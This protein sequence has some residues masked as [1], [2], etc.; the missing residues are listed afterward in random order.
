MRENIMTAATLTVL[1]LYIFERAS[2]QGD[3]PVEVQNPSTELRDAV[4]RYESDRNLLGRSYPI[5]MSSS[6][7]ER[8]R[9][10]LN[11]W[12]ER[13][14]R[15]NFD[16]L[17][18]DGRI[19]FLLFDNHLDYELRQ[20]DIRAKGLEESRHF[21][22]FADEVLL[23]E[24]ERRNLRFIDGESAAKRLW[25][26]GSQM[27]STRKALGDGNGGTKKTVAHRA[28][29]YVDEVR[30]ILRHWFEFYNGYDPL[31]T[32]WVGQP[33]HELDSLM[34]EYASF[35]RDKFVGIKADDKTTIIGDPIGREALM[36]ELAHEMIPYTPDELIAI[37]RK[38]LSWCQAEMRLASN[39]LG[40]GDDWHAALEHVKRQHVEPGK[41]TE[42][43]RDL[44]HEAVGFLKEHDLLTIPPLAEETWRMEMLSPRQQLVSPFFLGGEVIQVSYPTNTMTHE[45][46]MMSMRGNNVHFARATVFHE[47][48]PG[49]HLQGFMTERYKPYRSLFWTPF[50]VE[51]GALYWE[52][53]FWDLDFPRTPENRVGMLFWRMHRCARVIFSLSFHL[54]EM[55]PGDCVDM[56]VEKVGHERDNATAEVR[57]SFA[58]DYSPLYQCAYLIGALQFRALQKELVG[59]GRMAPKEFNNATYREGAI[60]IE[61]LRA[62]LAHLPVAKS[63]VASWRFAEE[64]FGK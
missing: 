39:A 3:R 22:P 16:S 55:S 7:R 29:R 4:E 24:E 9:E 10:F 21:L 54:G 47:L 48:I 35:I 53:T 46:K 30:D 50:W 26:I 51:G 14:A 28:A 61:M 1:V 52:M 43:I 58:G 18:E 17:S 64:L 20:L 44:A 36:V 31:F 49:H 42:L 8:T 38:E 60:P 11:D 56:L 41:Q 15:T 63:Y 32:W 34:R 40:Y 6:W 12:Q 59:T 2:S 25:R 5:W 23:L 33:Y 37:A 13:L 62:S 19:D 27:D 45:Q 57:R